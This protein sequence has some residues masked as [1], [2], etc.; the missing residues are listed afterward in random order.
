MKI[1]S[2]KTRLQKHQQG[3]TIIELMIS[4]VIFSLVL[5]I[6]L[7]GIVQVTR[8]YY[9]GV[10]QSRTQEVARNL[11]DEIT[12]TIQLSG[13]VITFDDPADFGP[14]INVTQVS[15]GIGIFCAGN[16]KYTY[17]LDRKVS[18]STNENLKEIRNAMIVEEE[19]CT[20]TPELTSPDI[21]DRDVG[22]NSVPTRSLLAENMRL[23]EFRVEKTT[24]GDVDSVKDGAD[25]WEISIGIAYGDQDLF[26]TDNPTDPFTGTYEDD[27]GVE[28]VICK[29]GT[30]DE[31]CSIITLSTIVSRRIA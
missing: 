26:S 24:P 18:E 21:L 3:F 25:L 27:F 13:S 31:F 20:N 6:C 4:T 15:Q 22:T 12:Q 19:A 29:S 30:G 10:T 14:T 11:L 28:R 2:K 16:K 5:L 8:A 23:T 17:A 1:F 9:K 7:Q